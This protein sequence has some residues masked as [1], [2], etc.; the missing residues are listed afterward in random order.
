MNSLGN[1]NHYICVCTFPDFVNLRKEYI[2]KYYKVK[3]SVYKFS[4]LMQRASNNSQLSL[5]LHTFFKNIT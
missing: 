4:Q 5:K 2:P 1:E 3:P